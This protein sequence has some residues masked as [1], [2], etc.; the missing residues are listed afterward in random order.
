MLHL[1]SSKTFLLLSLPLSLYF[2][3][4]SAFFSKMA[5]RDDSDEEER[6]QDQSVDRV[7]IKFALAPGLAEQ[8]ILD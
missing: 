5:D 8:G 7:S 2:S 1:Q 3:F 4:Y 6:P